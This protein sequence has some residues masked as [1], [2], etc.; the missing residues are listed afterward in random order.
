[1]PLFF[2]TLKIL[3]FF[4]R[5]FPLFFPFKILIN[6]LFDKANLMNFLKV[7]SIGIYVRLDRVL[8]GQQSQSGT[9]NSFFLFLILVQRKGA[10][11]F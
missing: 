10:V 5:F 8:R 3:F 4:I 11:L 6:F 1:M 9:T 7:V 2:S